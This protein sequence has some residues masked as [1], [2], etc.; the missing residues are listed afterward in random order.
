MRNYYHS[1][2]QIAPQG[3]QE[4]KLFGEV[5]DFICD[6]VR[7]KWGVE[8][9]G[10]QQISLEIHGGSLRAS[11]GDADDVA[12]FSF[13]V[14]VAGDWVLDFRLSGDSNTVGVEIDVRGPDNGSGAASPQFLSGLATKFHCSFEGERILPLAGKVSPSDV[15]TFVEGR[16][17]NAE[18]RLPLVLITGNTLVEVDS[19]QSRLLGIASVVACPSDV[20]GALQK[21][22]HPFRCYGGAIRIYMPGCVRTDKNWTQPFWAPW[23]VRELGNRRLRSELRDACMSYLSL[24]TSTTFFDEVVDQVR[25][26]ERQQ[27]LSRWNDIADNNASVQELLEE[28]A[29]RER[30]SQARLDEKQNEIDSLRRENYDLRLENQAYMDALKD[31]E[32]LPEED[33]EPPE[34]LESVFEVVKW[35]A[36]SLPGLRF[37]DSARESARNCGFPR[38][39]EVKKLFEVLSECGDFLKGNNN[40]LGGKDLRQWFEERGHEYAPHDSGQRRFYDEQTGSNI[41]MPAHFKLGGTE[42]RVHVAWVWSADEKTWLVGHVGHH[43]P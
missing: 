29:Q 32:P 20:E 10:E 19:L 33:W 43:L 5:E 27:H 21:E 36:R 4:K 37:L 14:K 3:V 7:Q 13:A 2:F 22:L 31:F 8:I 25:L 38:P 35:A 6:W 17:F 1:A 30:E 40:T 34:E 12:F 42:L 11:R 15:H 24:R 26:V 39:N 18:R 28:L 41:G 23:R 9:H 16:V